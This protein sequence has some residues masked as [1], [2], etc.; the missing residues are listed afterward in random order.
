LA[1]YVGEGGFSRLLRRLARPTLA[2]LVAL[3]V[4]EVEEFARAS[5]GGP[6]PHLA[7]AAD[8]L[9]VMAVIEA[10]RRSAALGGYPRALEANRP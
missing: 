3:L 10:A 7:T 2:N 6:A 8:G 1:R 4:R 5:R 9:A